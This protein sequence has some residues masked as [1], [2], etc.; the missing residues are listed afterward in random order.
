[1]SV[2]AELYDTIIRIVDQ[3]VGEIKVTRQ[4][5]DQ[6][7]KTI[8]ESH[9]QTDET[10]RELAEA[11]KRTD[12]KIG[13]LTEVQKT[14]DK[15]LEALTEAQKWTDEKL[16]AL[17]E[18]QKE[19][20]EAMKD[21]HRAVGGLSDTVGYGLEDVARVM[22]PPWLARHERV[23]VDDLE[24]RFIQVDGES[25]EVNLYG[26]GLK[27]RVP[28]KVVGEARSRIH[29]G[30]VKEFAE[31]VEKVRRKLGR[32][33]ILP[34][35]FGFWIHPTASTLAQTFHIHLVASYQR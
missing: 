33:K 22:L 8:V 28:I 16:G 31:N 5:F 23:R 11:Q 34:V 30:D 9:R 27:G 7:T 4:D 19:L 1:M 21:L 12:E 24:R 14:T 29:A 3:R 32:E 18:A 2:P 20:S 17:A 15:K 13:A 25:I 10:L 35:M 26:E 6:L